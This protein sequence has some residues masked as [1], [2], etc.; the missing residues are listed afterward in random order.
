MRGIPSTN[1]CKF[2][3]NPECTKVKIIRTIHFH[4][5]VLFQVLILPDMRSKFRDP[6][7]I[8]AKKCTGSQH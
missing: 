8:N 2:V 6:Y 1:Y 5:V 3:L 7:S 4:N